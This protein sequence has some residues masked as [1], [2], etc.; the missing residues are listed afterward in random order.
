MNILEV[1]QRTN[2]TRKQIPVILT[3]E[4]PFHLV[5]GHVI[6]FIQR[7][8]A[9]QRRVQFL[10][11][12]SLMQNPSPCLYKHVTLVGSLYLLYPA[13]VSSNLSRDNNSTSNKR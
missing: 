3:S 5:I 10:G 9:W 7:Q 12:N 4:H 6:G 8:G 11:V 1:Q 13:S 2:S